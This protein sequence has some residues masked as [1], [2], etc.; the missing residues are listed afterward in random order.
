MSYFKK[1]GDFCSGFACFAALMWLFAEYMTFDLK[2]VGFKEKIIKFFDKNVEYTHRIMLVLAIMLAISV[3]AS[4]VLKKVPYLTLLFS[5]PTL[6]MS[7][8]MVSSNAI[9]DYPMMYILLCAISVISGVWECI[10]KDKYDGGHRAALAGDAVSLLTS[11]ALM[12]IFK[13]SRD[14]SLAADGEA[15]RG[16]FDYAVASGADGMNMKLFVYISLVYVALTLISLLFT[17]VYFLDALFA[18]ISLAVLVYMWSAGIWTVHAAVVVTLAAI[19][20]SVRLI[21]AVSGGKIGVTD[22]VR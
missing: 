7:V 4:V 15:I 21:P 12:L 6:T 1:F 19:N 17:D 10:G 14:I 9:E 22:K 20:F 18:F 2:D 16:A 13:K 8:Y 3:V 11:A 5:V